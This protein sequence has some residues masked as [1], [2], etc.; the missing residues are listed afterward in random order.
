MNR[1]IGLGAVI[2][3]LI[4]IVAGVVLVQQQTQ[5]KSKAATTCPTGTSGYYCATDIYGLPKSGYGCTNVQSSYTCPTGQYCY[6]CTSSSSSGSPGVN[7]GTGTVCTPNAFDASACRICA[8]DGSHWIVSFGP[9]TGSAQWCSCAQKEPS[10]TTDPQYSV[11]PGG[12]PT[13]GGTGVKDAAEFEGIVFKQNNLPVSSLTA[14]Q[15]YDVEITMSNRDRYT[16][17]YLGPTWTVGDL[18]KI[19]IN[20]LAKTKTAGYFLGFPTAGDNGAGDFKINTDT[21]GSGLSINTLWQIH[22]TDPTK[23][24]IPVSSSVLPCSAGNVTS[25]CSQTFKTRV[26]PQKAGTHTFYWGMVHEGVNW[27]GAQYASSITVAVAGSTGPT[28]TT[29]LALTPSPSPVAIKIEYKVAEGNTIADAKFNLGAATYTDYKPVSSTSSMRL[30]YTF[31][32]VQIGDT[33]F[34]AVQFKK[35]TLQTTPYVTKLINFIGPLPLVSGFACEL[36]LVNSSDL[37]FKF[38]GTNF[39]STK[40]TVN[41]KD[42]ASLPIDGN[43]TDSVVTAR[44]N[45]P[46]KSA[47][48]LGTQ[49][50]ATLTNSSGQKSEQQSCGVGITQISLG[51]KLFCRAPRYFDQEN[52]ELVL[53]SDKDRNQKTSEKVTID[54]EGD[55]TNIKSKLRAGDN[56]I[57]CIK[58]PLSLRRCSSVFSASSGTNNISINLPIGDY[59]GDGSINSVDGSLLK[60]QWGPISSTK[61]C[62]VNKDGFCNSFEWSCMLHDFNTS[63]QQTLP[64]FTAA[65]ATP[66][67][68]PTLDTSGI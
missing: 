58:A 56:Y 57:A 12:G 37:L 40:G 52:V 41:L 5:L 45:S 24:R 65:V 53:I 48:T 61:N 60:G 43:W 3:I 19:D 62:D 29:S 17:T 7:V 51:A 64:S 18:S 11:C 30:P 67:P 50:F 28:P 27:F 55:I 9:N 47:T 4:G 26:T 66:T 31:S 33:K 16:P 21:A 54:K 23:L 10:F 36:D 44:L 34:L 1:F 59:N 35:G 2:I 32:N 20:D 42:A 38:T 15:T 63:D 14:G 46:P 39:G 68:T 8:S 6:S 25:A 22:W 49:Y 13:S